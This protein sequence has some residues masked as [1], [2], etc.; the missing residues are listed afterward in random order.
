MGHLGR[1]ARMEDLPGDRVLAALIRQAM[2]LNDEGVRVKRPV[3]KKPPLRVP[4]AV[5]AAIRAERRALATWTGF[6]PSHRR[7]Y[8]EWISEAKTEATRERRIRQMIAL[9]IEGK[10]RH[11]KYAR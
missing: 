4:A 7:E 3:K 1:I 6:P 8:V 9:L 10:H 5:L 2:R 11:W